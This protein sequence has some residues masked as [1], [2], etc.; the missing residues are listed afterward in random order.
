MALN[1]PMDLGRQ[2][3]EA[4]DE[5]QY[6]KAQ[7]LIEKAINA[8]KKMN[9]LTNEYDKGY[10]AAQLFKGIISENIRRQQGLNAVQQAFQNAMNERAGRKSPPALLRRPTVMGGKRSIRRKR[11]T[12]SKRR[13]HRRRT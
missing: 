4:Y 11:N 8:F 1:D 7:E 5:K 13:T 6:A 10:S 3:L 2:A 9:T 12:R